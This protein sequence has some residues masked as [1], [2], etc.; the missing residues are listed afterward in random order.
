MEGL[1]E[2]RLLPKHQVSLAFRQAPG[3]VLELFLSGGVAT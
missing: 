1:E 3:N 2:W